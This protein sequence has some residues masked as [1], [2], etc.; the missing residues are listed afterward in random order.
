MSKLNTEDIFTR[1][2]K[3][4][5]KF[6]KLIIAV[7]FDGTIT[8]SDKFPKIGAINNELVKKMQEW[9]KDGHEILVWTCRGDKNLED[10]K[11]FLIK[12]EIPFDALN[13]PNTR[14]Y[15][16]DDPRKIFADIYI[17]DKAFNINDLSKL[18][19]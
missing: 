15:P 13:S 3:V 1:N 7:D 17:D 19:I 11:D 18:K 2:F 6:R 4:I 9:K 8:Q 10:C 12:N 14:L 5:T 16:G